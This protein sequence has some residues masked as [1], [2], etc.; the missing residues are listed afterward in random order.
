[1]V[2]TPQPVRQ[3]AYTYYDSI[4]PYGNLYDLKT[5]TVEE[6]RQAFERRYGAIFLGAQFESLGYAHGLVWEKKNPAAISR[7]HEVRRER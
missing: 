4:E 2:G 3:V 1:M 5:A 7:G 6:T